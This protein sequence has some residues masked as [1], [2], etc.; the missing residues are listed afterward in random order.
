MSLKKSLLILL[1]GSLLTHSSFAQVPYGPIKPAPPGEILSNLKKLNVLGS[2]LYVAAH[3]DDENTLLLSYLAKERLVRT[4]YLSLT[5]GDGGQN[6]IGPEQGENIGVIRT[7]ELLAAR[8]VDGPDQ[9]FS[10]AYDF[11]FSKQ[12]TEAVRTWGQDKVLADVVWM[13][14]KYQPDVIMTRFPPDARAGHGHHSASGFLAEEAFKISNDPTKF[15]EQLAYVKPWQAKRIMW[16]MF[17]PGAFLSNKKP[18]EAGNLIGIETG[19][20][21]PLLGRSYGEIASESRSQHKSQGFGVA[22]N[23]GAKIDYLL[24]K[25]GDPVQKDPMEGVDMTWK[26]VPN[27][28]AVQT[29]VNQT[30]SQFKPDQ[31]AASVPALIQLYGAIGKLDTTNIY[32]KAKRQEVEMLIRQCLGLWFETNPTDYAAT[33]GETIKLTTNIV[34]RTDSPVTLVHIHYSTGKDSTLNLTLKPNDVVLLPTSVMIPKTAKISQPYWLEKPIDKGL[35]QVDNQQLIGLPE[36]PPALTTSYTF[37]ISGQRFTFSRP[38]VYKSTDPVDGEIYRP[39]IIQPAVTANLAERVY[40]FA[41]NTPK[42]T[43]VVLKAGRANVTGTLRID[44]P[45]GWRIDPASQPFELK[46]KGDEQRL[47]F[48]LTPSDKAQNGKLQAVMTTAD[49]TFTT[50]LRVIAYKHIPT[51]TLFP[52][53]EAKLV[54]LDVKV[55]AKNIGYIVGAGDEVPAA[56]Q[57]MGC[58]VNILGPTELNGNLSAYDAIVVGVRAYNTNSAMAR[59]QPKLMEYVKNGGTMVVQYVTPNNS[60]LRNE[61]QL[62]PLGP[63]PFTVVNERVTEEDAPMT[64]INPKHPLLNYPNKI[65]EADFAGWIQ[66]RGIYFARDWDKAYEPIFSSHDQNEA[67]KE[68]SLIYAKYGKGHY[69]YTGLVFF[70]ELPAGIPGAYRL[71]ANLI[72]AGK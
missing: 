39:F 8:R 19:L 41:D 61:A 11:G 70:R 3:P 25:G 23:R 32:V 58:R 38:V 1:L 30:I 45:T 20:F 68:G 26:R 12:T 42:T 37:D 36:N 52:Q 49:G 56:L 24:L 35:F 65:T 10:R 60:F 14:R 33:P 63:Y 13:I 47:S 69:M 57:Q 28:D 5:R 7:Q 31:P 2:V 48:R 55:T 46:N 51:Q 16:N 40:T 17:I 22:P 43:E 59:Y 27:S 18:E 72:S 44:V 62:P 71:F 64:F 50:G 9:F 54:K 4:G 53:A 34:N 29:Q 66:E 21:N 6:L 15:P 67:P